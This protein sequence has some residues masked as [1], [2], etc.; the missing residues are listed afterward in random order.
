ML[1]DKEFFY[2]LLRH[3]SA[4]RLILSWATQNDVTL[5]LLLG[6]ALGFSVVFLYC[7]CKHL[8]WY[9]MNMECFSFFFYYL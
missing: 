1:N 4:K 2:K 6:I 9:K 5:V 7:L 8:H 3:D